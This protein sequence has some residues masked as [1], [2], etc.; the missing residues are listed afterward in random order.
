MIR[1]MSPTREILM[2][3]LLAAA[4]AVMAFTAASLVLS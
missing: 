1:R 3:V 4:L 2:L